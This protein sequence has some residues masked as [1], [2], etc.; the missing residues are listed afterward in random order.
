MSNKNNK[1]T[2]YTIVAVC[3]VLVTLVVAFLATRSHSEE[4]DTSDNSRSSNSSQSITVGFDNPDIEIEYGDYDAMESLSKDIQN[5][6]M[7][8]KVVKVVGLVSHPGT[9]YSVV[10]PS[11]DGTKKIGTVFTI[12]DGTEEDYPNDGDKIEITAKVVET[13]TLNFQLV[14]TK[15][16]VSIEE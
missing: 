10:Q 11:S 6:Y 13:S 9:Y 16:Y 7:T 1:T 4:G 15:D 5:G 12:E 14:T 8:G 3:V 2:I